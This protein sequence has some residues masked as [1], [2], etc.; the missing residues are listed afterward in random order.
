VNQ[1]ITTSDPAAVSAVFLQDARFRK[2]T[3]T[4]STEV[5]KKLYA[6]AAGTM[7]RMSLELGGHAPFLAFE[8]ADLDAAVREVCAAKFRNAG[9]TCV[10]ANRIYVHE[11]IET[12]FTEKL[13]RATQ[14]LRVGDPLDEKTQIGPLVDAQGLEKVREHVADAVSQGA[15]VVTGGVAGPGLYYAPTVLTGVARGMKILEEETF[16][17]VAPVQSFTTEAEAVQLANGVPYGLAAYFWT[18]DLGRAF[19]VAE[20]LDYGIVG[21]NDGLPS[22]AQAPFGGFKD[23]GIGREGGKWGLDEYLE[24]KYISMTIE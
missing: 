8:D 14:A 19:R 16:G 7:K 24:M 20:G 22:T 1:V 11:S 15:T 10:C 23:S 6:Q 21:L 4:G 18:R 5:G 9:Q 12:A 2:L 3:F 13:V 17:P